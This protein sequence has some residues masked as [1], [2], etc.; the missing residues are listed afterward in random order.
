[1]H[2]HKAGSIYSL[3]YEYDDIGFVQTR[4]DVVA[5]RREETLAQVV[6]DQASGQSET[7]YIVTDALGSTAMVTSGAGEELERR[8]A[9][10]FDTRRMRCNYK[11]SSHT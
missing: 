7:Q 10:N 8:W 5:N 6:Y 2:K 4:T 1:M 3:I 11:K 9:Q